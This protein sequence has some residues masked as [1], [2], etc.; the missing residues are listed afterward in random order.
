MKN[1]IINLQ[2]L[3]RSK[4]IFFNT[5]ELFF[6]RHLTPIF[7]FG[8]LKK[9][10]ICWCCEIFGWNLNKN[11]GLFLNKDFVVEYNFFYCW[12]KQISENKFELFFVKNIKHKYKNKPKKTKKMKINFFFYIFELF[13]IIIQFKFQYMFLFNYLFIFWQ[14]FFI[15]NCLYTRYSLMNCYYKKWLFFYLK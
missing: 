12:K 9:I 13:I 8:L 7:A 15:F 2:I 5:I 3:L 4:N 6:I 1:E 11:L 14:I 10:E